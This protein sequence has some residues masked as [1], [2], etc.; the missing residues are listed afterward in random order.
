MNSYLLNNE[1]AELIHLINHA[2]ILIFFKS[3]TK[4]KLHLSGTV[5][6]LQLCQKGQTLTEEV[7]DTLSDSSDGWS[8]PVARAH[9]RSMVP[10]PGTQDGSHAPCA[11]Q[12]PGKLWRFYASLPMLPLPS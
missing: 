5:L 8:L 1:T 12:D 9:E 2:K 7:T 11:K 3:K 6:L 10:E 4:G